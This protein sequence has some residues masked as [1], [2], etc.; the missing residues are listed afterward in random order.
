MD[1]NCFFII[2]AGVCFNITLCKIHLKVLVFID[3]L[4]VLI[5]NLLTA[6]DLNILTFQP[7]KEQIVFIKLIINW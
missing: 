7:A 3:L 6:A 4:T 1:T 2:I 5:V